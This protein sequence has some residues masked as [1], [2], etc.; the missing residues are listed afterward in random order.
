MPKRL[1]MPDNVI[2]QSEWMKIINKSDKKTAEIDIDGI[3][4]GSF[5]ENDDQN[6]KNTVKKMKAE[7]KAL[8]ELKVEKIIVNLNSVG[9]DV[10]HGLSIHDLLALNPA[11]IEVNITGMTASI[12]TV[13]A[14]AGDKIRMSD[15]ALFLIHRGMYG[16]M[17]WFNQNDIEGVQ[18]N[19][20]VIDAKI[21]DIYHKR[22][23]IDLAT[24][25]EIMD[26][27]NGHGVWMDAD[28]AKE[29]GF[30]HEV[31][32]PMKAAAVY[33][34]DVIRQ[35]FN[36]PEYKLNNEDMDNK[37]LFNELKNFITGLFTTKVEG[38]EPKDV[39]NIP[40]EVTDKMNEFEQNLNTLSQ[41][42]ESLKAEIE[43]IN[44][45]HGKALS[46]KETEYQAKVDGLE[47]QITKLKAQSTVIPGKIGGEDPD[48]PED[49][50]TQQ[51]NQA[52]KAVKDGLKE[53]VPDYMNA[54]EKLKE[55]N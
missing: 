37:T 51:W 49:H 16:L 35:K 13:I 43:T 32:E 44:A 21:V 8:S 2:H 53:T 39:V 20:K 50:E 12:A 14:M 10:N 28:E 42:N 25:N 33:V 36:L 40:Q 11:E 22:T 9:G 26:K 48:N 15:N 31:F 38:E 41:E 46:D 34:N 17:G 3:I 45:D 52:A 6:S 7:L 27:D 24:V 18:E 30:V 23:G 19:L 1:F 54:D 55:L 5:W 4:G 47:S 29:Y